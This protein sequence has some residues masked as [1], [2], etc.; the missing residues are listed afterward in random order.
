MGADRCESP[1]LVT[2][3][4]AT[5]RGGIFTMVCC[6][7]ALRKRA[8][9]L[10]E[11]LV[12]IGIIALLIS[13]LLP[14]LNRAREAANTA[15][16][17][18]NM[19]QLQ[20]AQTAYASDNRGYLVQAGMGEGGASGNENLGWFV[21]LQKYSSTSMLARC[22][23]DDSVFWDGQTIGVMELVNGAPT[24]VQKNRKTSYGINNFLD[25]DLCP[26]GPN[27]D[28]SAVPPGGL[29]VKITKVRYASNVV[30]FCEMPRT[31]RFAVADHPH[32]ENWV[33]SP[34]WV[35][36][37]EAMAINAHGGKPGWDCKANYSF[38]DGHAETLAFRDVF[39]DFQN[40]KF[41]PAVSR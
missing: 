22:P 29:Y 11:L 39:T 7:D 27:Q 8:F 14:A 13:I 6:S 33:T 18:S 23:S 20:V 30:Q 34:P 40:N 5:S 35:A 4:S 1:L 12:V 41:D 38:L 31:G 3:S 36:A 17:L 25:R 9:T 15:K 24:M 19:R 10:V 2:D 21:A 16:C 32:V 28:P 26:W 37:S